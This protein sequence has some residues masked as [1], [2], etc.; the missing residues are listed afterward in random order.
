MGKHIT[1]ILSAFGF[2]SL[3]A[4]TA[5]ADLRVVLI[6]P[7]SLPYELSPSNY[8][9]SPSNYANSPSNYANSSSNYANSPSKYA[10]SPSNYANST[11]GNRRLIS[12]DRR[13][14]GYYVFSGEGVLNIYSSRGERIAFLPSGGHTQSLFLDEAGWCGT[15]GEQR[16]AT[17]L[18]LS[19]SCY[20]RFL[21]D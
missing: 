9:N 1:G 4:H 21:L 18:G 13:F 7:G 12:E 2:L 10:N 8:T 17:V 11:S 19:Q 14:L 16:G 6:D 20:L 5:F 3:W 15:I